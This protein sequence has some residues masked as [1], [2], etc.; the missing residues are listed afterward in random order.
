MK[1]TP[2]P[3]I[4]TQSFVSVTKAPS[5]KFLSVKTSF[6][7]FAGILAT[8]GVFTFHANYQLQSP[9][10]LQSPVVS[11]DSLDSRE[12]R[13]LTP[14][15]AT[16]SPTSVPSPT[17]STTPAPTKSPRL[18]VSNNGGLSAIVSVIYRLESSSGKHDPCVRDGK[19]FNGYGFSPGTCYESHEKVTQLVTNWFEKCTVTNGYSLSHCACSYNL[20][21]NSPFKDDCEDMSPEYPYYKNLISSL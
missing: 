8:I 21:P 17:P 5:D 18:K 16:P 7:F 15:L 9:I 20:G 13:K 12:A 4:S 6:V 11:R 10:L 19:G 2:A 14:P 3:K 1:R